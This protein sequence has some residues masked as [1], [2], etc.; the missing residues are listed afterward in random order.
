MSVLWWTTPITNFE[1]LICATPNDVCYLF[2]FSPVVP[3]CIGW[4][5][6][7]ER[8]FHSK[9]HST[10]ISSTC[11]SNPLNS[12]LIYSNVLSICHFQKSVNVLILSVLLFNAVCV[13][14]G[15]YSRYDDDSSNHV[16]DDPPREDAT[17][18]LSDFDYYEDASTTQSIPTT[19]IPQPT[20]TTT[21]TTTTSTTTARPRATRRNLFRARNKFAANQLLYDS[22]NDASQNVF[23]QKSR[24]VAE[25]LTRNTVTPRAIATEQRK[26]DRSDN[27]NDSPA[28]SKRYAR[29]LF[30]QRT[31]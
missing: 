25:P 23:V 10:R 5:F 6:I 8:S 21:T 4:S 2:V 13:C 14:F 26:E 17:V 9:I 30:R 27:Y 11:T 16:T 20:T 24:P 19:V 1:F 28:F 29:F 22:V 3:S 31:G 7:V 18:A 15:Q 12:S